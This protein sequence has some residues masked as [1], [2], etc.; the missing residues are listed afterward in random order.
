MTGEEPAHRAG[1]VAFVGRPNAGKSTLTNALVG[2]KIVITSSSGL[3]ETEIQN[4]VKEGAEHEK[5]DKERREQIERR[6]KLDSLCYTLEKMI[7]ENK[8]KLQA[9]DITT[10][11]G[12]IKDGRSAIEKQDD[13]L[14]KDILEKLEKEAHRLAG[15]MYQNAAPGAT[16]S[17][18][19]TVFVGPFQ[20]AM[21]ANVSQHGTTPSRTSR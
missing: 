13:A 19:Q 1:F 17:H 11:E 4:M 18:I 8:E 20:A 10:L 7:S 9:A 6:N 2:E 3:S 15:S 5:E 12:L 14:V 21:T 16:P